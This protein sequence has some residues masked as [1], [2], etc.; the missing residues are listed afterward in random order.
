MELVIDIEKIK[1]RKSKILNKFKLKKIYVPLKVK[2]LVIIILPVIFYPLVIIYFNKYQDILI[3]S[4]FDA[5]ERQGLTFSKV[6]GMADNT[7]SI[8]ENNKVSGIGLQ[9][10]LAL[11]NSSNS[12]QARLYNLD[13]E[14]IADSN[15]NAFN[16][17]VEIKK[18]PN[19][20]EKF[21]LSNYID[22]IVTKFSKLVSQPIDLPEY[23]GS[24]ID[25]FNIPPPEVLKALKGTNVRVLRKDSNDRFIL[26]VALPVKNLR[27]I[28]GAVLISSSSKKIEMELLEN[29]LTFQ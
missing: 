4:E 15:R 25:D 1:F 24:L 27:V 19:V 3:T 11:E 14:L 2:I 26:F 20:K 8:I 7:Y 21:N 10:L 23:I 5:I 13:G 18:L 16:S 22:K 29:V 17:R 6:I 28:R 9:S 12:L